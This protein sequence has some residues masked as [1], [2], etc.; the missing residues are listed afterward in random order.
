LIG[1]LIEDVDTM[2]ARVRR[3]EDDLLVHREDLRRMLTILEQLPE[4]RRDK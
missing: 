2:R 3:L 1:I 4:V